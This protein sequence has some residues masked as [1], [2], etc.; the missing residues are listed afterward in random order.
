MERW[1]KQYGMK[2]NSMYDIMNHPGDITIVYTSKE[3]QPRSEVFDESY[4]FVAHQLLLEKKWGVFL[5]K[6]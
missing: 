2:C 3:Y 6:I 4:K 5:P 1:N